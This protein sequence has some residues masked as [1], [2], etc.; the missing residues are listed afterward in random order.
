MLRH[1]EDAVRLGWT[2][3]RKSVESFMAPLTVLEDCLLCVDGSLVSLFRVEG[4]RSIT[5]RG[6]LARF[7]EVASRRLNASLLSRGHA[8]HVM[9]E[10]DPGG[11]AAQI[12]AM[13]DRQRAQAGLLGLDLEDLFRERSERLGGLLAGE[14]CI[15][16]VW[17][18][19]A[20]L[21]R[22]QRRKE[23]KARKKRLAEWFPRSHESQCPDRVLESLPPRHEAMVANMGNGI[24]GDG[25]CRFAAAGRRGGAGVAPARERVGDDGGRLA[26]GRAGRQGARPG[27]RSRRSWVCIRLRWR[28]SSW[29]GSRSWSGAMSRS[30]DA[31]TGAST[32]FWVRGA[33]G[34]SGS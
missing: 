23:V 18:R 26:A 5:G 6:E 14:S 31:F 33:A 27:R 20:I 15:V 25:A 29:Y 30:E 3:R 8:L 11:A 32:W 24:R 17:T 9:F 19:E 16:A 13:A 28:R 10:R 12:A 7:V 21:P 2:V 34:R 1:V 4:A 22:A